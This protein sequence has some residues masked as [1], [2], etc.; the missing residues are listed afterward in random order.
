MLRLDA[1]K[2][3]KTHG[4]AVQHSDCE[5]LHCPICDGGLYICAVCGAAEVEAIE[6]SCEEYAEKRSL[7]HLS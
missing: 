3:E 5:R 1:K 7:E 2:N 6:Y 4:P